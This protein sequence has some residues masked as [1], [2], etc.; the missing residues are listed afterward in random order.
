MGGSGKT[1]YLNLMLNYSALEDSANI[2]FSNFEIE[3]LDQ[4]GEVCTQKM[5][6]K[7]NNAHTYSDIS[8]G[9]D[10]QY[11]VIDTPGFGD[12]RGLEVDQRHCHSIEHEIQK[13]SSIR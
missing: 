13:H 11:N 9:S 1:S 6:S 2:D 12:T 5:A 7:T 4:L 8:C 3:M 10:Y